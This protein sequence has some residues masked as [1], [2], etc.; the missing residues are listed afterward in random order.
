[1]AFDYKLKLQSIILFEYYHQAV[2]KSRPMF[3]QDSYSNV[4]RDSFLAVDT[5]R[6]LTQLNPRTLR[7]PSLLDRHVL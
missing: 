1:M 2:A 3:L 5:L 4:R 6:A 7:T